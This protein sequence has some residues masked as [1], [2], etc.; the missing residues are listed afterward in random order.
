LGRG[1]KRIKYLDENVDAMKVKLSEAEVKNIR[2]E[3][4]KVEITGERYGAMF[5]KY[6]FADTPEL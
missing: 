1:T 4:E 6:S 2:E 5:N 3:I